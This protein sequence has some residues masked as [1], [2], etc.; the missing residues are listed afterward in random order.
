MAPRTIWKTRDLN[1]TPETP[2]SDP[3]LE[4][5]MIA[6]EAVRDNNPPRYVSR[7]LYLEAG[8][9]DRLDAEATAEL[10]ET[11]SDWKAALLVAE[12]RRWDYVFGI[13]QDRENAIVTGAPRV[14]MIRHPDGTV[15][16]VG[17]GIPI[18][19]GTGRVGEVV[20]LDWNQVAGRRN[21]GLSILSTW[22][23]RAKAADL[24][25]S[26]VCD[27]L[28]DWPK[29]SRLAGT[30]DASVACWEILKDEVDA[31]APSIQDERAASEA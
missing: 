15:R 13:P 12:L 6:V 7:D 25:D 17:L 22:Y 26:F 23:P 14:N 19:T 16:I 11:G 21:L 5:V 10:A 4:L 28:V 1:P 2:T 30:A 18:E 9:R 29:P 27:F 24:L 20:D 31:W 3:S 8:L